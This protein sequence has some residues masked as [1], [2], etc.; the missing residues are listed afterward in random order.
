MEARRSDENHVGGGG[1]DCARSQRICQVSFEV[2]SI[3]SNTSGETDSSSR[4]QNGRFIGRKQ[5]LRD[6]IEHAYDVMEWQ[7]TGP[8]WIFSERFDVTAKPPPGISGDQFEA[9]MQHLLAERFKLQI[10]REQRE[11]AV[12]ALVVTKAGLKM[13]PLTGEGQT[14]TNWSRDHI[15]AQQM[16]MAH[17]A[18]R[19]SRVADRPVVDATGVAGA[20]DFELKWTPDSSRAKPAENSGAQLAD[21]PPALFTAIEEQ[22]GLKLEPRKTPVEILVVDHAEK[23]PGEN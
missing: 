17:F 11:R 20:F 21:L 1:W 12:Y 5:N 18:E 4:T 16:S 19:L 3:R 15:A 10:H 9:M 2:A 6:L 22:L 7:I 8:A 13:R 23:V 14:K